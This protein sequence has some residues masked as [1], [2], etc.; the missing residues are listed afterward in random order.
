MPDWIGFF[1]T[2]IKIVK[3]KKIKNTKWLSS[4]LMFNKMINK[5]IKFYHF[6]NEVTRGDDLNS[7]Y[8]K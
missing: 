2:A 7:Q 8:E 3:L 4:R 6:G 5:I 1:V